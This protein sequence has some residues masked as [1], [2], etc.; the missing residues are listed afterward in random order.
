MMTCPCRD[1]PER[2]LVCHDFCPAYLAYHDE[3]VAA[4]DALRKDVGV[5]TYIIDSLY[6]CERI[7]KIKRVR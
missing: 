3:R 2:R 6:R 5:S 1:C 4:K 7:L